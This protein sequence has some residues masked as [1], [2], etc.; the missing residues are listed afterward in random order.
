MY[1]LEIRRL[2]LTFENNN[3]FFLLIIYLKTILIESNVIF[4]N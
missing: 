4:C 3:F 1:H 2:I